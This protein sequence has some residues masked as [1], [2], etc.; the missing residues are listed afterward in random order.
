MKVHLDESG[1]TGEDLINRQQPIF[2]LASIRLADAD[3]DH[4]A[5]ECFPGVQAAELK[6]SSLAKRPRGQEM[7]TN[8]VRHIESHNCATYIV[9]KE[10]CLLTKLV[11]LWVEPAMH[12]LGVDFYEGGAN[13][14]FSNMCF[15]CLR[16]FESKGFL[17][18]HLRRFQ[19]MSRERTWKRY[20][21]FWRGI[22]DDL[23][24][25]RKQTSEIMDHFLTA[26]SILGP[27]Q[28]I[29]VGDKSLDISLT[30]AL[31]LAET[32]TDRINQG[33]EVVHD[34]SSAMAREKWMWDAIV[35]PELPPAV[36]GFAHR[37]R[38]YPLLVT[39]TV[40]EDSKAN[41]QLQLTDILAG[42]TAEW[43]KGKLG[44]SERKEYCT[45]LEKAGIAKSIIGAI[46]PTPNVERLETLPGD[47]PVDPLRFFGEIIVEAERK[48]KKQL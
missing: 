42:A 16:T 2:V 3:A 12:T 32:W 20:V 46:W 28:V 11:D 25:C 43:A 38:K 26:E 35:S 6:H 17:T 1:F 37:K 10:F 8:F 44:K 29:V 19:K 5:R 9:H 23:P 48:Q 21:A 31:E 27:R 39:K 22:Y 18:K 7:V 34:T 47:Q 14:A 24:Q 45:A 13:I 36:V 41:H 40:F 33:F 4:L 15:F 30:C